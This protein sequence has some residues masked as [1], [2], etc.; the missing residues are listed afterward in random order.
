MRDKL[1]LASKLSR[2][3]GLTLMEL[4]IVIGIVAVLI[5]IACIG[6][7]SLRERTKQIQCMSNLKQVWIALQAYRE[8]YDGIDPDGSSKEYWELGLP[9]DIF[10]LFTTGYIKDA[11]VIHCPNDPFDAVFS[12]W[13]G[14]WLDHEHGKMKFSEWITKQNT[15]FA[16]VLDGY[17]DY[18]LR[19][20]R[21]WEA[22]DGR[23]FMLWATLDGAIRKGLYD[24]PWDNLP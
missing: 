23:F 8:D 22:R 9:P 12:Y 24:L 18:N 16:V 10:L 6:L 7:S 20:L 11:Q 14:W 5:G 15:S 2:R 19:F 17:H 13:Q 4:L 1:S 3:K 21:P